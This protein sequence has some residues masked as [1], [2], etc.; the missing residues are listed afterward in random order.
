MT[1]KFFS[2]VILALLFSLSV[3]MGISIYFSYI[4]G[5]SVISGNESKFSQ[6]FKFFQSMVGK[7]QFVSFLPQ[8]LDKT[9]FL[10]LQNN[11]ELRPSGGF[12]GSYAK[13][14]FE[15]GVLKKFQ[16]KDIYEPDGQLEGH[17]EP[18]I[19][20]QQ[21]SKTGDWRLRNANWEIDFQ[22]AARDI[23]WFFEKGK[24]EDV[25]GIIAINLGLIIEILKV[26]GPIKPN[27]FPETINSDNFYLTN[28]S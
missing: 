9:Y 6:S 3:F 7:S 27:D 22:E 4:L 15:N 20:L 1:K 21:A 12:M 14:T 5:S 11:M 17:V 10:I 23:K 8:F 13:I 19:P 2:V 18:P 24:E 16:V 26:T 25:Q 28:K